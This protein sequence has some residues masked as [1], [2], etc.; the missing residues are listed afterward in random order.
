M[1]DRRELLAGFVAQS[2]DDPFPLYG[3]AM[4]HRRLGGL[5]EA[6][7]CFRQL[8]EK[9]SDYIPQYLMHGQL[10]ETM[11]DIEAARAAY[12]EGLGRARSAGE[13]HAAEELTAA[14]EAL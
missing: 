12:E 10:L 14:I 5:E 1:T 11:D 13:D 8:G 9:F 2:P 6:L 7:D 3:L 4:E